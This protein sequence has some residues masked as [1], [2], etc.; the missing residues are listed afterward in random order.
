MYAQLMAVRTSRTKQPYKKDE[1]ER[2]NVTLQMRK[3]ETK[4]FGTTPIGQ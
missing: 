3:N 1:R 4:Y 2:D